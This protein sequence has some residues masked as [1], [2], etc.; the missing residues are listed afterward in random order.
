GRRLGELR[1]QS[2][3]LR[4]AIAGGKEVCDSIAYEVISAWLAIEDARAR[5]RL[6]RTAVEHAR[7][8]MR[9]EQ[10]LYRQGDATATDMVDAELVRVRSEQD[11][12]DAIYGYRTALARLAWA[13]GAP[14][15]GEHGA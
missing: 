5:I 7:E 14:A 13:T 9:V 6:G 11:Y 2:A 12:W 3:A 15:G 10:D 1:S 8:N 4:E